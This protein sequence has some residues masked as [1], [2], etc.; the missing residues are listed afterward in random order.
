MT[1]LIIMPPSFTEESLSHWRYTSNSVTLDSRE[2][3]TKESIL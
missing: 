3:E 2:K 1:S